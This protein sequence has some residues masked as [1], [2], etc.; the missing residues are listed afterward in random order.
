MKRN[1]NEIID[2]LKVAISHVLDNQKSNILIIDDL[3]DFMDGW[4]GQT[5]RKGHD[6]PQNM[7]N[8]KAF[9]VGLSFKIQLVDALAPYYS[10]IICNNICN[11]NHAGSFG[12]TVNQASKQ[13]LE[14]K[15][16]HVKV[17]NHR[18]F[19]VH[20]TF[21][22][23]CFILTHGKDDKHLKFGFKPFLDSKQIEKIEN[24]I[25]HH[26]LHNYKIEFSKGD[27]HQKI[28]DETTSDKF[29]YYNYGAFSPSSE[30]VQTNFKKGKS[31]FEFFNYKKTGN[32]VHNP[33]V[34]EWKVN[35]KETTLNLTA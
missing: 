14:Y 29:N 8:E 26:D 1:E 16:K 3:G 12:Y 20:Y 13:Y 6:L 9:D 35:R 31:F 34:F 23:L 21:E 28:F 30:W 10:K 22:N 15:Y 25:N 5:V 33:F 32:K 11:D 19:I 24:Y 7:D 4:N 17:H 18:K 2:R 27:S